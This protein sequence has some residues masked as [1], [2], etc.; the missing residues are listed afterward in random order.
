MMSFRNVTYNKID[1]KHKRRI[2]IFMKF[3]DWRARVAADVQDLVFALKEKEEGLI[4]K[5]KFKNCT[6]VS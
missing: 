3:L 1:T 2:G 5:K 4:Q 6:K